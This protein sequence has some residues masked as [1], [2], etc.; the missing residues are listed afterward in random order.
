MHPN[1]VL[2]KTNDSFQTCCTIN[3]MGKKQLERLYLSSNQKPIKYAQHQKISIANA[4][5]KHN[6]KE[7]NMYVHTSWMNQMTCE[8]VGITT[9]GLK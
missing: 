8:N 4:K 5:I 1:K 3:A 7:M 6:Q 2:F 9:D